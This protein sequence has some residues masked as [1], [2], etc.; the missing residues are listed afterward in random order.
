MAESPPGSATLDSDATVS[1][2][3]KT[4]SKGYQWK[5]EKKTRF[6]LGGK[7]RPR[8]YGV[9][10]GFGGELKF[11]QSTSAGS[12]RSGT[13]QPDGQPYRTRA[14][15]RRTQRG[16][17]DRWKRKIELDGSQEALYKRLVKPDAVDLRLR[18]RKDPRFTEA[19]AS[20]GVQPADLLPRKLKDFRPEFGQGPC[21]PSRE[22]QEMLSA[23]HEVRRRTFLRLVVA[24][25]PR[26]P[27]AADG[28]PQK[29][30]P[31]RGSSAA[32]KRSLPGASGSPSEKWLKRLVEKRQRQAASRAEREASRLRKSLDQALEAEAEAEYLR[33][34]VER[35]Q[36]AVARRLR[37]RDMIRVHE[38]EARRS[39]WRAR[40]EL[41]GLARVQ[42][43]VARARQSA[44]FHEQRQALAEARQR[45]ARRENA[46]LLAE[47]QRRA[48]AKLKG[49][50][51]AARARNEAAEA[52]ELEAAHKRLRKEA[53]SEMLR[54][55]ERQDGERQF[56]RRADVM[57][58]ARDKREAHERRERAR[59][60]ELASRL[61]KKEARMRALKK[62]KE[63]LRREFS[64]ARH[65]LLIARA[66]GGTL[67]ASDR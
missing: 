29:G 1:A 21:K 32:G 14:F 26:R 37:R 6:E 38:V 40:R 8:F 63:E 22:T 18:I 30:G 4:E 25:L 46:S 24:A 20:V 28:A 11:G 10:D 51:R 54:L 3:E 61:S 60:E 13:L 9:K 39:S 5:E 50:E 57:E 45:G 67:G 52:A 42:A 23:A 53:T 7:I 47:A 59:M 16:G 55:M 2:P 33:D 64:R 49:L 65:S 56:A 17:A 35:K 66:E 43:D 48:A 36:R 12:L 31:S 58:R 44:Q 34:S 15:K 41:A 19:C 62:R 27:G